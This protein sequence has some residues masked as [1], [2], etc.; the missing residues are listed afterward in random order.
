MEL[1]RRPALAPPITNNQG[2]APLRTLPIA[3]E[4]LICV[5]VGSTTPAFR[6]MPAAPVTSLSQLNLHDLHE[7]VSLHSFNVPHRM[8]VLLV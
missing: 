3:R 5:L 2:S 8:Q 6:Y 4:R 7:Y 1:G